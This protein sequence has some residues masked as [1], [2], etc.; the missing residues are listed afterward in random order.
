MRRLVLPT[1]LVLAIVALALA[2]RSGGDAK[3]YE[4]DAVFDTARG[5]VPGQLVKIAGARVGR[6]ED[7]TLTSDRKASFRLSIE[8]RFGPLRADASCKIL[9]EGFIS[10]SFVQCDA[11]SAGEPPLGRVPGHD[12]PTVPVSRT[13]VS[14]QLQQVIDTFSLPVDQR[15]RVM[16]GELGLAASGTGRDFNAVLRRA[17]PALTQA[18]RVLALID[19]QRTALRD[20]IGQTDTV[21]ADMR[22]RRGD[23]RR[24]VAGAADV[25]STLAAHRDGTRASIRALPGLLREVRLS[26]GSI[27]RVGGELTP[28]AAA[29]RRAVPELVR[30]NGVLQQLSRTGRPALTSLARA[31]KATRPALPP[32]RKVVGELNRFSQRALEPSRLARELLVSLRDTG[33]NEQLLNMFYTLSTV[34]GLY[35]E[36]SHMVPIILSVSARCIAQPQ[37]RACNANFNSKDGVGLPINDPEWKGSIATSGTT[38]PVT[39]GGKVVQGRS[40]LRTTAPSL[41]GP[42]KVRAADLPEATRRDLLK[43]LDRMAGK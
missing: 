6:V 7:V 2:L 26:L 18:N 5:M 23:V 30:V 9:P 8:E 31:A 15:I 29:L 17:N 16:L 19:R 36:T 14:V 20:A 35:D 22:E 39:Q 43:T 28:T 13:E 42:S 34:S 12:R 24:F 11:G 32:T 41:D 21:L 4:F 37:A 38:G 33:G 3:R 40:Q 27:D 25:T 1:L 10:E